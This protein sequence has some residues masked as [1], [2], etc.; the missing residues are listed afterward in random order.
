MSNKL[1]NFENMLTILAGYIAL[2]V[3]TGKSIP[4]NLTRSS[5]D[6]RQRHAIVVEDLI[7][8]SNRSSYTE[9]RRARYKFIHRFNVDDDLQCIDLQLQGLHI[10]TLC[11]NCKGSRR[12]QFFIKDM[13][14]GHASRGITLINFAF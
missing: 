5:D 1:L 14:T 12:L 2:A 7:F 8:T 10:Y 6:K 9:L 4:A 13:G 3:S 11:I